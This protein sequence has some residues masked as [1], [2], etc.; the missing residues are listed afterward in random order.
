[1]I[2]HGSSHG[3]AVLVCTLS[4][5]FLVSM[6]RHYLP[7][8]MVHVDNVSAW[9]CEYFNLPYPFPFVEKMLVA[10][11]AASVWGIAFSF[12]HNDSGSIRLRFH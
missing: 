5:G 3:I 1:M 11:L 9:L 10:A 8:L 6:I 4:S 12:I 2:K 7:E